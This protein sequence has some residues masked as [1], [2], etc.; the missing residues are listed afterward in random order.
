MTSYREQRSAAAG[1]GPQRRTARAPPSACLPSPARS[2]AKRPT[3]GPDQA[4]GGTESV[5]PRPYISVYSRTRTYPSAS[6][7]TQRPYVFARPSA[8]GNGRQT[9]E[10]GTD[11]LRPPSLGRCGW[12]GHRAT[13]AAPSPAPPPPAARR[14]VSTR[15]GAPPVARVVGAWCNAE[16][17][18]HHSTWHRGGGGGR[19]TRRRYCISC[20]R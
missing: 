15:A 2:P 11:D 18:H 9:A 12:D 6:V 1:G 10:F 5:R 4:Q 17:L 3:T 16:R 7:Q 13:A 20:R 19:P 14:R 8:A